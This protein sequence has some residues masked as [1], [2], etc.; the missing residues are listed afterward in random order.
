MYLILAVLV[1]TAAFRLFSS[2]GKPG[3]LPN[4]CVQASHCGGFSCCRA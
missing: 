4:F 2:Y 1:F 3:L